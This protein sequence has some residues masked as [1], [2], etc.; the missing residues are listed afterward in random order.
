MDEITTQVAKIAEKANE[1]L[2]EGY[3]YVIF[4]FKP[5]GEEP[6][7]FA[8]DISPEDLPDVLRNAADHIEENLDCGITQYN[9]KE[10]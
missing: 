6:L 9:I 5:G 3:G 8:S 7:R 1:V 10:K 4:V 2:P